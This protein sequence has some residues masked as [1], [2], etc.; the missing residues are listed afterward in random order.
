MW[1]NCGLGDEATGTA[2]HMCS[3]CVSADNATT[4]PRTHEGNR[5]AP[6]K[7]YLTNSSQLEQVIK[8]MEYKDIKYFTS[9]NIY[10]R[11]ADVH[12]NFNFV[13]TSNSI[14]FPFHR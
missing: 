1:A 7:K 2:T 12:F 3:Q 4:S 5:P 14:T 6:I 13:V 10:L 11:N 9:K 8:K